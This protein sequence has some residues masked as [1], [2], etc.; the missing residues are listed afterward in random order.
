MR[1]SILAMDLEGTL[2][3]N[4]VSQ[5][6]RPG[7]FQ[8]LEEV[9]GLFE[10]LVVYTTVPEPTFRKLA[11]LLVA[12][13][14]APSWFAQLHYTEWNG[15]TKD[16]RRVSPIPNSTLL[17][18]DYGA[19]VHPGQADFWVHV[20]LFAAPYL[21]DDRGLEVAIDVIRARLDMSHQPDRP[22]GVGT[23]DPLS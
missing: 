12:E 15:S 8:F 23:S 2:I 10:R 21:E 16:L 7:L 13:G 18:D 9:N 20:P 1:P 14:R 6:P 17:L 19:Y 22:S 3:S 5:I 11:Y 4:A